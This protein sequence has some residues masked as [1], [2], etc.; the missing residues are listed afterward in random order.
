MGLKKLAAKVVEY[1]ERLESG[2]ASKIK[3][4]H[5]ASVLAKLRKKADELE[6][7]IALTQSTEKKARLERK[8]GV[9]R[10]H[11]ARAEWL[12]KEISSS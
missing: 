6:A 2:K 9:A 3:P 1:N 5:V 8:L 11:V 7:K 4:D 12:L 10:T